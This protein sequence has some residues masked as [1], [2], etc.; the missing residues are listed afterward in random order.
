MF[1]LSELCIK[2]MKQN[3]R[4]VMTDEDEKNFRKAKHCYLCDGEFA[5]SVPLGNKENKKLNKVRD[6]DHR[7][8]CFRGAAHCKCNINFFFQ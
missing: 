2:E 7:T 4:M 5:P 1:E 8:G 3:S 6:H